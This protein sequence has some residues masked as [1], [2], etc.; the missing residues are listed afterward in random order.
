MSTPITV[1]PMSLPEIEQLAKTNPTRHIVNVRG[2]NPIFR[3]A[4]SVF[5]KDGNDNGWSVPFDVWQK[6]TKAYGYNVA[7]DKLHGAIK[8]HYAD[9]DE[10]E[11][12]L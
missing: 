6:F 1:K 12:L 4:K 7:A 10:W 2:R 5:E 3:E 11:K 8:K 9:N